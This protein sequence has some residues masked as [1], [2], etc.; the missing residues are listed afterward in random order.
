MG[1]TKLSASL[2][3]A[4]ML[5]P[6][7]SVLAAPVKVLGLDDMS[8]AEWAKV[9]S[10][11]ELSQPYVQWVRGFLTGHNYANQAQQVSIVSKG[12]VA[13]YLDRYCT[14]NRSGNIADAAMRMSDQYSGRN[15]AITR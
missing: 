13:A 12:T 7:G 9:S 14:T 10:D 15:A 1:Y 3:I 4:A 2:L 6:A 5:L 8:C 11:A